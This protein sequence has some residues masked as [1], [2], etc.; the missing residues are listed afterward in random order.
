MNNE[1]LDQQSFDPWVLA[2]TDPS[3]E[4]PAYLGNGTQGSLFGRDGRLLSAIRAGYYEDGATVERKFAES[5][6]VSCIDYKQE[7]DMSTGQLTTDI[8]G[9]STTVSVPGIDWESL[10][11]SSDIAISGDPEAQQV[12]HACLFYLL[13]SIAPGYAYSIPPTGLSSRDWG[14]DILWDAEIWMMP[15]L[16]PQFP[17]LAR[18]IIDY[19]YDRLDQAKRNAAG[20]GCAGAEYPLQS[21]ETGKEEAPDAFG[22]H[23]QR[24]ITA[25]VALSTWQYYLWTGDSD[26]LAGEGWAILQACADYWVSRATRDSSGKYH[27]LHVMGPD[28]DSGIVDD[29]A[30]TN[31]VVGYTLRAATEA[32]S[33]LGAPANPAWI[34]VADGLVLLFDPTGKYYIEHAGANDDLMSKQADTQMLIYPL[35]VPMPPQVAA[36]T[37]DFCMAHT[38]PTGPCMTSCINAVVAARLGRPQQSLDLFRKSYRPFVRSGLFAFAETPSNDVVYVCTG[39]GGLLQSVL[40]GFAGLNVEWGKISGEGT[41][42][43]RD[44]NAAMFADPHLPSGWASM[45]LTGIQ[46]RGRTY[47]IVIGADNKLNVAEDS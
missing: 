33:L 28:E 27:I 26:F 29:D 25:D 34:E 3:G 45:T 23:E 13:C 21:S 20:H 39:M 16:L 42:V 32:A 30:W 9:L 44:G 40:Y 8:D 12:A 43:A 14:G 11:Q 22:Y 1:F 15:A 31:A 19:R 4:F 36:D 24:H 41:E 35:S 18:S 47:T 7:L 2:T 38:K 46:F 37:L 6:P 17:E 10:W 5:A